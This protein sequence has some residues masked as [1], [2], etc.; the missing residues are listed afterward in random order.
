MKTILSFLSNFFSKVNKYYLT[1]AIFLV[2]TFFIGDS[3]LFRRYEY[4]KQ[5]NELENE[6]DKYEKEIKENE[7]QLEALKS[8]NESLERFAREKYFMTKSNEE[9][10]IIR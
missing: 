7:R 3:T 6:I 5:I 9:L 10:F 2:I 4:D 1:G 8:D